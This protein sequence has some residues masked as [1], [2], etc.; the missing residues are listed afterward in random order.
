MEASQAY[1]VKV[2]TRRSRLRR[3]SP[4]TL[5]IVAIRATAH[6]WV[7]HIWQMLFAR[8]PALPR[9]SPLLPADANLAK[10]QRCGYG[11]RLIR[12]RPQSS[13][14]VAGGH[15][16]WE[17]LLNDSSEELFQLAAPLAV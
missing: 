9:R 1:V 6:Q 15:F 12:A 2:T 11:R 7:G 16:A 3:R 5:P 17:F 8:Q 14:R 13:D 4:R 10:V